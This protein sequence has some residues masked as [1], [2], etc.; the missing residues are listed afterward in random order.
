[1]ANRP[2]VRGKRAKT[3]AYRS[4]PFAA[5]LFARVCLLAG[6]LLVIGAIG[7]AATQSSTAVADVCAQEKAALVAARLQAQAAPNAE[8]GDGI[9]LPRSASLAVPA[10][11]QYPELPTGCESVALTNVLLS[12]G[13]D[14][15]K[16]EIADQWLPTSDTDFVNAFMGDPR[17]AEGHSCMA[18]AIVRAASAYLAAQGSSLEAVDLSGASFESLLQEVADGNPVLVWCTIDLQD[19]GAAYSVANVSGRTYRLFAASHCGVLSGYNLNEG[20]VQVSDS[21]AGAV[22]CD[23]ETFAARYFQ[24]GSQAVVIA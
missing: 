20:I 4:G 19:A 10:L 13:F 5:R 8:V 2:T 1:M 7:A 9:V 23:L 12:Y 15:Q 16:T 17:T 21:L 11:Q 6:T 3:T 22:A 18:P 24:L 14:L